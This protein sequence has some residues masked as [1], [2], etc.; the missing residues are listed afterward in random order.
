MAGVA[1]QQGCVI[2]TAALLSAQGRPNK[3]EIRAICRQAPQ[4]DVPAPS[5]AEE[6]LRMQHG[7]KQFSGWIEIRI[8]LPILAMANVEMCSNCAFLI[9]RSR[10]IDRAAEAWQSAAAL[11]DYLSLPECT[12]AALEQNYTFCFGRPRVLRL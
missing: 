5:V 7:E 12:T 10:R 2:L 1:S 11:L 6:K 9:S 3:S 4:S 8:I